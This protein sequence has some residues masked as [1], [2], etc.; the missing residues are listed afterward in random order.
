MW[1]S[2]EDKEKAFSF[3]CESFERERKKMKKRGEREKKKRDQAAALIQ[4]SAIWPASLSLS[5]LF[6]PL[7]LS[8]FSIPYCL[9]QL[10]FFPHPF[11]L[12][13]V[14]LMSDRQRRS[15]GNRR[16]YGE[17]TSPVRRWGGRGE[18]RRD[19][20]QM[21]QGSVGSSA[22][23]SGSVLTYPQQ[24]EAARVMYL[25]GKKNHKTPT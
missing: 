8:S 3:H 1:S 9:F 21:K 19:E 20:K 14:L 5:L 11:V 6:P 12:F 13:L 18:E 22:G 24:K 15:G 7:S 2:T 17:F 16:V 25:R 4:P 10:F 23:S